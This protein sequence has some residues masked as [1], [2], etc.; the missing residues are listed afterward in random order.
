MDAHI[1]TADLR[2]LKLGPLGPYTNNGFILIDKATNTSA[3]IDAIPEIGQVLAAAAGT[4][5]SKVLF[6][7]SH[8]DHIASLDELRAGTAAPFYMHPD[9]PYVDHARIDVPLLDDESVT[10]GGSEF[11]VIHTPGHTP[12]G[13][14]FYH[15]PICVVGDTLFPGGPG[16]TR[17]NADLQTLIT[18]I[19]ER[20]LPLPDDTI[21]LNGH[22]EETTIGRSKAEYAA[23][24]A[25]SHNPDL[26]GDVLWDR[27]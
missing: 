13:L 26:H 25:R 21:T 8:P 6:T 7:H 5:I 24:S 14:C 2:I 23:F 12:G 15:A 17:S 27:D 22:G 16:H 11:S 1:E 10:V 20:L 19:T 18:S 4:T 9:E 3:I